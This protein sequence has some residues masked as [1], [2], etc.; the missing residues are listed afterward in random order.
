VLLISAAFLGLRGYNYGANVHHDQV[1]PFIIRLLQPAAFA[2][3]PY[4]ATF[5]SYPSLFP[6]L[7]AGL[8]RAC[9]GESGLARAL[10]ALYAVNILGVALALLA[11]T[12][13]LCPRPR[14]RALAI[15]L[16]LSSQFLQ[17]NSFFGEDAMFRSYA[18]GSSL[19]WMVLL[20]ALAC[21]FGGSRRAAAALVGLAANVNPLPALHVGLVFAIAWASSEKKAWRQEA[22]E[23][24]SGLILA[25]AAALPIL[26]RINRMPPQ[27]AGDWSVA[28]ALKA[29]YPF[30]YFPETWPAGK[31]ALGACSLALYSYLLATAPAAYRQRLRP[32]WCG[33]L[34]L[35]AVGLLGR[36]AGSFALLRLQFFRCDV[37]L[38]LLGILLTAERVSRQLERPGLRQSLLAGLTAATVT[39][40]FCWPLTLLALAALI[41]EDLWPE[42]MAAAP[43]A[44]AFW[45][46]ALL[47]ALGSLDRAAQ[48][49][50][51]LFSPYVSLALAALSA[52]MIRPRQWNLPPSW[53]SVISIALLALAFSPLLSLI[54]THWKTKSLSNLDSDMERRQ[55]EWTVVQSWCARN[56]PPDSVFLVD[57]MMWGFR[58]SSRRSVV[59]QWVDGAAM[60]WAPAY[61]ALWRERLADYD[62]SLEAARKHWADLGQARWP[63]FW[64][65]LRPP[66]PKSALEEA[67]FRMTPADVCRLRDKYHADYLVTDIAAAPLPLP[68]LLRGRTFRLHDIRRL[69][70]LTPKRRSWNGSRATTS[71]AS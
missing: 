16:I 11:L 70:S 46:A 68:V 17:A 9:G 58:A 28:L 37:I 45:G 62:G 42:G 34:A 50:A 69:R 13:R 57:P 53:R 36:I 56:T 49:Q 38:V 23:M 21:W 66:P 12:A 6:H 30:H 44:A 8:A 22:R 65:S 71:R 4:V 67:Y 61:A 63:L 15:A 25:C 39:V 31:W 26:W 54:G 20:G 33:A 64:R 55:E 47:A 18:D 48:G 3:D 43:L 60:H 59:F 29:W 5:S 41:M 52:L 2:G 32:L 1:L 40:W 7:A 27:P 14:D 24:S 35:A 19:A 51:A 10:A